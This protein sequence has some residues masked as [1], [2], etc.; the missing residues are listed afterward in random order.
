MESP[1]LAVWQKCGGQKE[2]Q[3]PITDS[4]SADGII[5]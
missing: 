1:Q 4:Y 2:A 3:Q 5:N